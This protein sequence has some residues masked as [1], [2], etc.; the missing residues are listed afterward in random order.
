MAVR[1]NTRALSPGMVLGEMLPTCCPYTGQHSLALGS[2]THGYA[3]GFPVPMTPIPTW[4]CPV[5]MPLYHLSHK[6]SLALGGLGSSLLLSS[7]GDFS[8]LLH[9]RGWHPKGR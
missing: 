4:E 3:Q 6:S 9:L 5:V 8:F 7:E 2:M 1:G